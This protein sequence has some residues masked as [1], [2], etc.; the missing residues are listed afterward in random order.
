MTTSPATLPP[1]GTPMAPAAIVEHLRERLEQGVL[2]AGVDYDQASVAVEPGAW[3]QAARICKLEPA[4]RCDF[5]DFLSG[6][7]RGDHGIE[8]VVRLYSTRHRHGVILRA[9]A[10]GGRDRPVL[11]SLTGVYHGANWHERETYDMFGVDFE[12]HPGLLPRIL[13]VENFEGWPLRKEFLLST[14]EAKPWPGAKEPE[15]RREEAPDGEAP[16]EQAAPVPAEDKAAAAKA[17]AER[18]KAKAAAMRAR[19]AAE[20]AAAQSATAS[21][22]RAAGEASTDQA[23]AAAGDERAAAAQESAGGQTQEAAA[24]L[25]AAQAGEPEPQTPEGAAEIAADAGAG[26]ADQPATA[27][28]AAAGAVGGDTAAGAPGDEAG[29]DEP[30]PDPQAEARMAQGAAPTASGTPG[31]EQ[32]GRH[33]GAREQEATRP[34]AETPGM[35]A[36]ADDADDAEPEDRPEDRPEDG[37]DAGRGAR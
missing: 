4:L 11:P 17:K 7:D 25:A 14:R 24:G 13:T 36:D 9:L 31:V 32:E 23:D 8:V 35:T 29:V 3:V 33:S 2:D 6:V 18:A 21:E 28:D 27:K 19:K 15:E 20:R 10:P 34:A 12:G 22:A 26:A 16:T 30:V 1:A 37:G 5:F